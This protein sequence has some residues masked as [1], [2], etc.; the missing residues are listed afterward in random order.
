M[1]S[2][3]TSVPTKKEAQ[4]A[5]I[6]IV[7]DEYVLAN[8]IRAMVQELGYSVDGVAY[9]ISDAAEM[10][11]S[12]PPDVV[13][14]DLRLGKEEMGA[15]LAREVL[16]PTNIPFIYLTSYTSGA[17]FEAAKQTMPYG[18]LTK[19]IAQEALR[20]AIELARYKAENEDIKKEKQVKELLLSISRAIASTQNA[21]VLFKTIIAE[22][23]PVFDFYD[24]G[25]FVVNETEDYHIDL[26]AEMPE[27]SP[28]EVAYSLFERQLHKIPHQNSA[29]AW[30]MQQITA[31]Q[32]LLFDFQDLMQRFPDYPQWAAMQPFG[33][34][35]CLVTVLRVRGEVIGMF[36][37]NSLHKDHFSFKQFPLFQAIAD[38]V[39]IT[40]RNI[41]AQQEVLAQK[42][43]VEQLLSISEAITQIKDRKQLLKTIYER[44]RPILPYDNCGLFVLT[45]D[46]QQHYE[47][48]D[49]ETIGYDSSQIAI[50]QQHGTHSRYRHTGSAV[51]MM[52]QR[53]PGLFL[54]EDFI[55]DHPQATIMYESGLRQLIAG[56]LTYGGEAIGMLC[57]NSKQEDFYTEQHLPLF[58]AISE[59]VS[60]AVANVLANEQV[61]AEKAQ[62]EKLYTLSEVIAGI[63]HRRQLRTAFERIRQILPYNSAGLFVLTEDEQHHYELLDSDTLNGDPTQRQIEDRFGKYAHYPHANSP[64]EAYM[65][66]EGPVLT[67]VTEGQQRFPG[68]PQWEALQQADLQQIMVVP[69]RQAGEV[70][71][72]L[73]LISQRADQ[74]SEADFSLFQTIADQLSVAVANVLANER[75]QK[76]KQFKETLLEISEVAT[77]IRDREGLYE[78]VMDKLKPLIK[79]DDAVLILYSEE[80]EQFTH[81]QVHANSLARN[82]P[83]FDRIMHQSYPLKN[84]PFEDILNAP[85]IDFIEREAWLKKHPDHLGL[86]MM[87]DIG[88]DYTISLQLHEGKRPYAAL[89]LHFTEKPLFDDKVKELYANIADQLSVAVSNVLAN[90]DIQRREREQRLQVDLINTFNQ[91]ASWPEKLRE[92]VRLLQPYLDTNLV[93]FALQPEATPSFCYTYERL[94]YEEYR[95]L[96]YEG[97]LRATGLSE[98]AYRDQ[99]DEGTT[100]ILATKEDFVRYAEQNKVLQA[101]AERFSV[102]SGLFVPLHLGQKGYFKVSFLSRS[103]TGYDAQDATLVRTLKPSL[104]LALEKLLAYENI[105]RLNEALAREKAYL[106]EEINTTYDFSAMIGQTEAMQ[107]VF[108]RVRQVSHNDTTVLVLGETGTGKELI[109]RA[110]HDASPR[111]EK[112]LVKVNCAALP[113]SLIDSELFGHEKGAFTGALQ[114]RIGKFELAHEG[115]LF[116]DEVGE[117]PLS[118]QA[119]LLRVLQEKEFE[120][121]GSNTTLQSD[122]RLITATNR[123]LEQAVQQ[124]TFRMDLYYRLSAFP[125]RLP[126]LRK[127]SEDLPLLLEHY[128]Q[129]HARRLGVPYRGFTAR[130]V[131][132]MQQYAWPGNVRELQ[133][134]VE[135]AV[136]TTAGGQLSFVLPAL[137]SANP[138]AGLPSVGLPT[139]E[140]TL[141]KI[142]AQQDDL[143]RAHLRQVLEQT[144]W[145]IRG[146]KGAAAQLGMK[147][148]TLEY[149]LQ[150]LGITR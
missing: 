99:R 16:N 112:P 72:L 135:Q 86:L 141:E 3:E 139:E 104:E 105:A 2:D 9:S 117:L 55:E 142:K 49:A 97:F 46:E 51:D 38:Q 58:R 19:P 120:R 29:V 93:I 145:R 50:E 31:G 147:P 48:I 83:Y 32:P 127:R 30:M 137:A 100:T 81:V 106:Q 59:Q 21:A 23:Q 96:D 133:N 129:H 75:G 57:F 43:R 107:A 89:L 4:T 62:V 13:L 15:T 119:K 94:T 79:F 109:A 149:R 80:T 45:E 18:Y 65:Q 131:Q 22:L 14:L 111:R 108:E 132:Q 103:S 121:L 143:E 12:H 47:L 102:Q 76:E 26:V 5:S 44:I 68:Y 126:P 10:I 28:S 114:R 40:L 33:Y 98:P 146:K 134:V 87:K 88:E 82:H 60:V 37:L 115:T 85:K 6:L 118:V 70:T 36:C 39:A 124:N 148:T 41:L 52:M 66:A 69:L 71:G 101:V 63:Q 125:V 130:A 34:R 64:I 150:K 25:L 92:V 123:N 77:Q 27:I 1:H 113:E 67:T 140:I 7:E 116:L 78:A 144:R 61:L 8:D 122:F 136:L 11:D 90:E 128:G 91:D 35:D 95:C 24:V 84:S 42:Q 56:P 74:Y 20:T 17:Y 73:N 54:V 53:G 110:L 138:E